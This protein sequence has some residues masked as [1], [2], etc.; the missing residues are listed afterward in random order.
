MKIIEK[1]V[2]N[3]IRKIYEPNGKVLKKNCMLMN[4]MNISLFLQWLVYKLVVGK[5]WYD[6]V[7]YLHIH[8]KL[9]QVKESRQTLV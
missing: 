6:I 7:W 2:L 9:P 8:G 3:I 5:S 1:Q 4:E